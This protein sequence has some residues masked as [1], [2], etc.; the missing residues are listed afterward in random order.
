[1]FAYLVNKR[2]KLND[3]QQM[4]LELSEIYFK[5]KPQLVAALDLIDSKLL[6]KFGLDISDEN[7][8]MRRDSTPVI[9]DP[10]Y[11]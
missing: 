10:I 7:V 9:I 11:Y 8:M 4:N 5:D 1:M 3:I 6:D 2:H